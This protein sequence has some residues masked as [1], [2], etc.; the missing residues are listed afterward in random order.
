VSFVRWESHSTPDSRRKVQPALNEQI[1]D[2][3]D[4]AIAIFWS[5]FG[6]PT[7]SHESGSLEEIRRLMKRGVRVLVYFGTAPIPQPSLLDG[8]YARLQQFKSELQASSYC[9]SYSDPDNLCQQLQLHL[10][11]V[12]S[13]R[14]LQDRGLNPAPAGNIATAPIPDVRVDV[15]ARL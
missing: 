6:T 7:E 5:R 11:T 14:L 13:E 8:Q 15:S 9:G 10:T 2:E 12:V 4:F 1:V 3:S